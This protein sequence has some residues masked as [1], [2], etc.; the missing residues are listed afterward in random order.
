MGQK[1]SDIHFLPEHDGQENDNRGRRAGDHRQTHFVDPEQGRLHRLIRVHDPVAENTFSDHDRVIDQHADGQHQ[2]HHRQDIQRQAKEI[3]GRQRNQQR[4]GHGQ[5]DDQRRAPLAQKQKQHAY[6]QQRADQ[7]GTQQIMQRFA[8]I[9]GLVIQ[10]E[11]IDPLH[12]RKSADLPDFPLHPVINLHHVGAGLLEDIDANRV[13]LVK[14]A[15]VIAIGT[16]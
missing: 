13:S 9:I 15:T 4:K 8:H 5:R 1:N 6:S 7:A 14:V 16:A 11:N 2:T 3:H 10:V 12:L